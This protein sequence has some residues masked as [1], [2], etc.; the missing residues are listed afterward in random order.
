LVAA[1]KKLEGRTMFRR[2]ALAALLAL[3]AGPLHA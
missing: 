1:R 3:A 2:L